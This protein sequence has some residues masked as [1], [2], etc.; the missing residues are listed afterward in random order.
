LVASGKSTRPSGEEMDRKSQR[1]LT[2]LLSYYKEV[3][4]GPCGGADPLQ[5][6][7]SETTRMGG[8]GKVETLASPA[9]TSECA[10]NESDG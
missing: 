5:N 9:T 8:T 10:K 3:N 6:K 4:T 7:K 2:H 1:K